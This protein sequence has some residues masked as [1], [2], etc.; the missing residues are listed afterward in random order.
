MCILGD[1]LHEAK[2][3]SEVCP[4]IELYSTVCN[5]TCKSWILKISASLFYY[6]AT[7]V[8]ALWLAAERARFS[9]NDRALWKFFS[10]RRLFWVVSKS[11][12]RKWGNNNKYWQSITTFSITVKETVSCGFNRI[13]RLVSVQ[14][15][16]PRVTSCVCK[17]ILKITSCLFVLYFLTIALKRTYS[18]K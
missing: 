4:T 13:A 8:C 18:N 10:A 15:T 16:R 11:Y 6:V 9:C 7:I 12:E 14:W 17:Q 2:A 3:D 5:I 1:I